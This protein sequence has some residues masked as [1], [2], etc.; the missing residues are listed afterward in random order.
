M[1][2]KL[3]LSQKQL[4]FD[5]IKGKAFRLSMTYANKATGTPFDLTAFKARFV[6]KRSAKSTAS[7]VS[8][9][10]TNGITLGNAQNNIEI[11]IPGLAENV[12]EILYAFEIEDAATVVTPLLTGDITLL[13]SVI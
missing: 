8:L 11:I 4:D 5:V 7:V 12:S 10:E 2:E 1:S 13:E 6:A 3:K 9:D